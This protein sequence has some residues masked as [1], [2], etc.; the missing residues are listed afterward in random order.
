MLASTL[1]NNDAKVN[2]ATKGQK[3]CIP[4][5]GR[6]DIYQ[7]ISSSSEFVRESR[8]R[9]DHTRLSQTRRAPRHRTLASK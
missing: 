4:R 2:P 1:R 5:E 6:D 9:T 8:H 3:F 7:R